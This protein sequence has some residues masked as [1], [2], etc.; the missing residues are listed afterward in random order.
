MVEVEATVCLFGEEVHGRLP[1]GT[2]GSML[3]RDSPTGENGPFVP[4]FLPFLFFLHR[5]SFFSFVFQSFL[6]AEREQM[7]HNNKLKEEN[8]R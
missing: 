7:S 2:A 6:R 4:S 8:S 1:S 3:R 5:F